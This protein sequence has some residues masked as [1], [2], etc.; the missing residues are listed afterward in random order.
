MDTLRQYNAAESSAIPR[1][2][3][4]WDARRTQEGLPDSYSGLGAT[5]R[6]GRSSASSRDRYSPYGSAPGGRGGFPS[7]RGM[8]VPARSAVQMVPSAAPLVAVPGAVG[9]HP[10][11]AGQ[12]P[13]VLMQQPDGSLV[14]VQVVS[15]HAGQ[16]VAQ[17]GTQLVRRFKNS[18][19]LSG[20]PCFLFPLI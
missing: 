3:D 6:G 12:V 2:R 17:P 16:Y 1:L 18:C 5:G 14:Q 4:E 13:M 15:H 9:T 20:L 7:G 19:H 11:I 8:S 10:G